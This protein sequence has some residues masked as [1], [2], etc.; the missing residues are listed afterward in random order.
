MAIILLILLTIT[1]VLIYK[2]CEYSKQPIAIELV[3]INHNELR[4]KVKYTGEYIT[5]ND[6]SENTI[7]NSITANFVYKYGSQASKTFGKLDY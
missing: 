3:V 2:S 7:I 6:L 5:D 4:V 1:S